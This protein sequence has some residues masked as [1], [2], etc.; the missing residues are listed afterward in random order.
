MS[1]L[2]VMH[3]HFR[4]GGVRRVIEMGLSTWGQQQ[5]WPRVVMI[6]GEVPPEDWKWDL[7]RTLG[8]ECELVWEVLPGAGYFAEQSPDPNLGAHMRSNFES[9]LG[10]YSP[11]LV[12]AHNFS[13]GRNVPLGWAVASG[14]QQTETPLLLHH[15]DWWVDGRWERWPE[16][17][18][19]GI[20]SFE[21][22]AEGTVPDG[23]QIFHACANPKDAA[24]LKGQFGDR[25]AW[26]PPPSAP[27]V[28]HSLPEEVI[29][30]KVAIGDAPYWL[31]PCRILRRKNLL[32][33]VVLM[34]LLWPEGRLLVSGG[35]SS[36][37]EREHFLTLQQAAEALGISLQ[38]N[39]AGQK[40]VTQEALLDQ[41]ALVIQTSTKEGYGLV[42]EEAA[43]R[44]K[45]LILRRLP[46]LTLLQEANGACFPRSYEELRVP[47]ELLGKGWQ[48]DA[49]N[50]DS[51]TQNWVPVEWQDCRHAE[52]VVTAWVDF[53][54]LSDQAQL[55][56]ILAGDR[57]LDLV[58]QANLW[59]G[60]WKQELR[61]KSFPAASL[62]EHSGGIF[63]WTEAMQCLLKGQNP[64]GNS[65]EA[66]KDIFQI[67]PVNQ[68]GTTLTPGND[69][70]KLLPFNSRTDEAGT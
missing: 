38:T 67:Y 58:Q 3:F 62:K 2:F 36:Q 30:L 70:E 60:P 35:P 26:L 45:A 11:T 68:C 63:D 41:A 64:K 16:M 7:A 15:H 69:A 9:L 18:L 48:T 42:P 29:Q 46:A 13:V 17:Q 25:V 1:T 49:D 31:A 23:L 12:W 14:C 5:K 59:L 55:E 43:K 10:K 39:V 8:E 54:R 4:P 53:G 24:T 57:F 21:E 22:A 37:A 44:H 47:V 6:S 32:E 52:P 66:L 50:M 19:W 51:R 28:T 56:L 27:Q 33:A 40:Q 20:R 65:L 34:K 61:S